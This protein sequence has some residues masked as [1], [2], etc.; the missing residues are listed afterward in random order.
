M[1]SAVLFLGVLAG[2][3]ASAGFVFVEIGRYAEPQV[4]RT[5]F[6]ERK[7]LFAFTAGLFVGSALLALFVLFATSLAVGGL[8]GALLLF[9]GLLGVLE[10]A[11]L[12]IVR[13]V[14]F[15]SE[16]AVPFYVLGYRAGAAGLLGIGT[17]SDYLSL[18]APTVAGV[19]GSL[20]VA[21]AFVLLLAA[22][23]IQSTPTGPRDARRPG[24]IGRSLMLEA[25]GFLLLAIGPLGGDPGVLVAGVAVSTGSA[26]LYLR[27]R[28]E[29]LGSVRPPPRSDAP[30]EGV[31]PGGRFGRRDPPGRS[32]D[33]PT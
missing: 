26:G 21:V 16:P 23:G 1:A 6:N 5:L 2:V 10:I 12:L 25:F 22:S 30:G 8:L 32:A 33:P 14:Y 18:G 4:P 19:V 17:V 29:V 11:Q 31:A 9:L 20:T 28:E 24:S 15:G 27:R 7:L 3:V 13:S